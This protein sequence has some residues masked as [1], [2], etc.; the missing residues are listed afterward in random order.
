[1]PL[2]LVQV[3]EQ[4]LHQQ[5]MVFGEMALQGQ[6][7]LGIWDRSRPSARSANFAG[8]SSPRIKACSMARPDFPRMSEATAPSLMFASSKTLWMRLPSRVCSERQ[9]G[10]EPG[11]IPQLAEG[12]R[13]HE[14]AAQQPAR[15]QLSDPLGIAH[16]RLPAG[17]RFDD[18]RIDQNE[19]EPALQ[20]G[21]DRLPED[22]GR[23]QGHLSHTQGFQVVGQRPG[24]KRTQ[25]PGPATVGLTLQ[26]SGPP[27]AGPLHRLVRPACTNTGVVNRVLPMT[28]HH[29][30]E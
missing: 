5:P 16:I 17:H 18:P 6:F 14:A 11:Q 10:S 21:P 25:D 1:M 7:Q 20:D 13:R 24:V 3:P 28:K 19:W 12:A 27:Q 23:F 22:A 2:Q 26:I 15:P 9:L 8:S 29:S 4:V 30:H